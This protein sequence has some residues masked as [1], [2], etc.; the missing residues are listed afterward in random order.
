MWISC[1]LHAF[2]T[3]VCFMGYKNNII[4]SLYA[5]KFVH[6]LFYIQSNISKNLANNGSRGASILKNCISFWDFESELK[7]VLAGAASPY[8]YFRSSNTTWMFL[9]NSRQ[10]RNDSKKV[11]AQDW[12]SNLWLHVR[13]VCW[14]NHDACACEWSERWNRTISSLVENT[15]SVR[16][17]FTGLAK[18][19]NE[20]RWALSKKPQDRHV[21]LSKMSDDRWQQMRW[22]GTTDYVAIVTFREQSIQLDSLSLFFFLWQCSRCAKKVL[23]RLNC[24]RSGFWARGRQRKMRGCWS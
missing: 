1:R 17:E 16:P 18:L 5:W 21:S 14:Q 4:A 8:S 24:S 15:V 10:H 13:V 7:S 12:N 11:T 23:F 20:S 19:V 3:P 6:K 22:K 9:W 2:A